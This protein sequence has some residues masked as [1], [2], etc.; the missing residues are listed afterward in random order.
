M[1]HRPLWT[2]ILLAA[3]AAAPPPCAAGSSPKLLQDLL[4][5]IAA[6]SGVH[7]KVAPELARDKVEARLDGTAW[8]DIIRNLLRGYNYAGT[9]SAS[10]Q[11]LAVSVTGRNGDGR[12]P[13]AAPSPA[14]ADL[15]AYRP[16]VKSLP[17]PYRDYAPG[18]VH[19]IKVP[20]QKLRNMKQGERISASLP[21]GRY[22]LVHDNAWSHDN[23][24]LT[25]VGYLEGTQG[26]YRALLTLGDGALFGQIQTPGGLYKLDSDGSGE[27]LLDM[28]ASGLQRGG[29][30]NDGIPSPGA[31]LPAVPANADRVTD[32]PG[33][34]LPSGATLTED[35]KAVIE[36]LLLYSRGF[37][38]RVSTQLNQLMALANQA[39]VDSQVKAVFH[40]AAAQP[41]RYKDRGDN[42]RALDDLSFSRKALRKTTLLRSQFA[43]DVVV[44]ARRFRPNLQGG[45]CGIAW[46]NGSGDTALTPDQ[47]FGVIGFGSADGFFCSDY[48]LA[49]ELG[50]LL[51]ATHDRLHANVDGKFDFS[52]GYGVENRFGDIMSYFDPEAGI[53]ANPDIDPS[54]CDGSPCGIPVGSPGAANVAETFNQTAPTVSGFARTP[55]P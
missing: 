41:T 27:W 4:Q 20:V 39:L 32:H 11:L 15:L 18:S 1:S 16:A 35:G 34:T 24:D 6:P 21:D 14:E 23:G 30:E 5:A 55:S 22:Q 48:T 19:P 52:F 3:L 12:A 9:W 54:R 8:P 45:N 49:H 7:F 31:A 51:G 10:G 36:V 29:Y 43:A 13:M 40:L 25:W 46:V 50:H 33:V 47:A 2:A 17:G 53:Y 44:L 26:R 37:G 42:S 28:N 38:P